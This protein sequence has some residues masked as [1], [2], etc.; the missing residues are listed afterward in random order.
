[1]PS[2]KPPKPPKAS[3]ILRDVREARDLIAKPSAR[4]R[5]PEVVPDPLADVV[6]T[7][8]EDLSEDSKRELDAYQKAYRGRAAR[9]DDRFRDATDTE[10]WFAVCFTSRADKEE[11]LERF[12]LIDLGDKYLD[13]S[14]VSKRLDRL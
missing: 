13:G 1:M 12:R 7:E 3:D 14:L 9:E 6:Y 11:F 8:D 2:I 10:H 5:V 4:P